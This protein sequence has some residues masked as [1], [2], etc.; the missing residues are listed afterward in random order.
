MR[1]GD[2]ARRTG[3]NQR[4]LRY[5]EEQ[6]LLTPVRLGN[7][8]REYAEPDVV[9][10]RH[11]RS[12]L[13]AGLSTAVIGRMLRCVGD[14]AALPAPSGCPGF[15]EDLRRE[16]DHVAET[17]QRLQGSQRRLEE[18]LDAALKPGPAA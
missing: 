13:A 5:Y 11:I 3:V 7:G 17:I 14:D 1:I 4:L 16:R 18:L 6:G 15:I 8:Y 2:L 9:T 12:L 10:V